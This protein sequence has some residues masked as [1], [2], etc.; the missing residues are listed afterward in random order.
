MQSSYVTAAHILHRW[1]AQKRTIQ[2]EQNLRP[3]SKN[4]VYGCIRMDRSLTALRNQLVK[5]PPSLSL[6][7]FLRIGI[8]QILFDEKIPVQVAVHETVEAAKASEGAKGAGFV[9]AVLRRIVRERDAWRRWLDSQPL[10]VR[11]SHPDA[12]VARWLR[13]WS[14]S[15]VEALC[16]WNNTPPDVFLRTYSRRIQPQVFAETAATAGI[17]LSP[18]AEKK[19]FLLPRGVSVQDVPGFDRG[20]FSVQ[21]VSTAHAVELLDVQPG[22]NVLDMCAAPGGKTI[23]LAD[24]LGG[25]GHLVALDNDPSR[26]ATLHHSLQR[27]GL[28]DLP[29]LHADATAKISTTEMLRNQRV[30]PVDRILIDAPCTNTGVL[31]RRPEAR[32]RFSEDNLVH[33]TG[34][35]RAL[36]NSAIEWL[37]TEGILVY[38]TCSL[39]PEENQALISDW[40]QER[41]D[42]SIEEER[43]S[44][45][46]TS[47]TDGVYAARI[48]K[49]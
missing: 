2:T 24:A 17:T 16:V 22:M 29:V 21:D 15:E 44:F 33:Q 37:G 48:V 32:W 49:H 42:V 4:L 30:L 18:H 11:C 26:I 23:Q 35:Q 43:W 34:L 47:N 19:F 27:M 10:A 20:W 7:V 6:D 45:P 31:R 41:N 38:S 5:R 39:E 12:L 8:F 1:S 13:Q 28:G 25:V 9:N 40:L 3:H 14:E 46:P 36:L